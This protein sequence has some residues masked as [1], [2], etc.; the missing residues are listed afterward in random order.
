MVYTVEIGSICDDF[1]AW[2]GAVNTLDDIRKAGE[3][4]EKALD[5]LAEQLFSTGENVPTITDINDWLWHDRS[6]IYEAIGLDENGEVPWK[7]ARDNLKRR[8]GID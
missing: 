1:P 3:K 2:S 4:Y 7:N 5:A 8:L 6:S